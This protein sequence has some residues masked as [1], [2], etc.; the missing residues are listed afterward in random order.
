V[1]LEA[2]PDIATKAEEAEAQKNIAE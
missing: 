1:V 2:L